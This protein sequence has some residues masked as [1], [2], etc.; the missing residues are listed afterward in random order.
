[1]AVFFAADTHFDDASIIRYENRPFENAAAMNEAIIENWNNV[2]SE[3]DEVFLVGDVGNT[4]Y[5]EKLNGIKYL[6]KGNHDTLPD[7]EYIKSGF[8][9]VY[10]YPIIFNDFWI[11]SH[12]PLYV[13]QNMPYANIFGH[14]HGNPAYK[15]V[16]DRSY[17]VSLDRTS[18]SPISFGEIAVAVAK[19]DEI[20]Y[21]QTVKE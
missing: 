3:D 21:C 19:A 5:V 18:F 6:I 16:S 20:Y 2:V 11:V 14:V 1:M 8:V 17:C 15:T 13:N 4:S 9:K 12:E 7:E 10:D